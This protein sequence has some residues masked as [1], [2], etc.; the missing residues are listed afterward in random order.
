MTTKC[1]NKICF[2]LGD[3]MYYKT[4]RILVFVGLFHVSKLNPTSFPKKLLPSL[5]I[6]I[7]QLFII[8]VLSFLFTCLNPYLTYLSF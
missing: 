7:I 4:S 2:Y 5:I 3:R 6:T 8:I 1:T